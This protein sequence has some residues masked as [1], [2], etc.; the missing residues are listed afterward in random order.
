MS[1]EKSFLDEIE[2]LC[3]ATQV[4]LSFDVPKK[5]VEKNETDTNIEDNNET[6]NKKGNKK[7]KKE[8]KKKKKK[9][10]SLLEGLE[11]DIVD[12]TVKEVKEGEAED[13]TVHIS[14]EEALERKLNEDED[15]YSSDIIN[16]E[17]KRYK[18]KKGANDYE[19]VFSEEI[20]LL[21][22]FLKEGN[23]MD[24]H[25]MNM[26]NANGGSRARQSSKYI[27]DLIAART[28]NRTANLSAIK[29]I[30]STKDKIQKLIANDEKAKKNSTG[31]QDPSIMSAAFLDQIMSGMGRD[32]FMAKSANINFGTEI[33]SNSLS[34]GMIE[35]DFDDDLNTD[36]VD[37]ELDERESGRSY[38]DE[39]RVKYA[40]LHPTICIKKYIDDNEWEFG[41]FDKDG[42]EIEDYPL[43]TKEQVGTV[44]FSADGERAT[45]SMGN[46]YPVIEYRY[47]DDDEDDDDFYDSIDDEFYDGD[48][49]EE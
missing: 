33:D 26:I 11:L 45:D 21:Y 49:D 9:K 37:Q 1:K 18:N 27:A 34:D 39:L 12:P 23:K 43:H 10:Q 42:N 41:A 25:I 46:T 35:E 5:D 32:K 24:K 16:S 44:R 3:N 29:E 22:D 31:D 38:E 28:A 20:A 19:K 47:D 14:L 2:S 17:R 30:I 13:A 6:E 8:K 4:S 15:K 36:F 7:E 48:D 40:N